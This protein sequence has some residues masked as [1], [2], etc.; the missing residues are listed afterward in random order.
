MLVLG[1]CKR[2]LSNNITKNIFSITLFLNNTAFN[3]T[4]ELAID[5]KPS[6]ANKTLLKLYI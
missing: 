4:N 5:I 3:L 6:L 1:T 2:Y